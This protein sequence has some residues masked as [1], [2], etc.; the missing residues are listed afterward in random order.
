[1]TINVFITII[2]F[3]DMSSARA[4]VKGQDNSCMAIYIEIYI[5]IYAG[6]YDGKAKTRNNRFRHLTNYAVNKH[7]KVANHSWRESP[8]HCSAHCC[9]VLAVNLLSHRD[10]LLRHYYHRYP[11]YYAVNEHS[12]VANQWS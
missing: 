10:L 1:M 7:S 9:V 3:T 4:C 11:T 8:F 2:P 5:Y 12:R 6:Q